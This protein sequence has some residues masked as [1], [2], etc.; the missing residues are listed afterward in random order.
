MG[1]T[2]NTIKK[3]RDIKGIFHVEMGTMKERSCM[4][5]TETED[6]KKR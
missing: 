2:I 5:L 6:I 3:V 1:E 4:D